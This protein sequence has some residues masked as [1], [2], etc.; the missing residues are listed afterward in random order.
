MYYQFGLSGFIQKSTLGHH[1]K[2]LTVSREAYYKLISIYP[3]TIKF[4]A[5]I[6][7]ER[8]PR[9]TFPLSLDKTVVLTKRGA[10]TVVCIEQRVTDESWRN[11]GIEFTPKEWSGLACAKLRGAIYKEF[12]RQDVETRLAVSDA[13]MLTA[14]RFIAITPTGHNVEGKW[15]LSRKHVGKEATTMGEKVYIQGRRVPKPSSNE[16]MSS[17]IA[18]HV[19][20]TAPDVVICDVCKRNSGPMPP[21]AST[22]CFGRLDEEVLVHVFDDI[23]DERVSGV[24]TRCFGR[25]D[26]EVL[27]RVLRDITDE[28]VAN[29]Y[30]RVLEE[31]GLPEITH[32]VRHL[33]IIIIISAVLL[34]LLYAIIYTCHYII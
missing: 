26:E 29:L 25:V 27:A 32:K 28:R 17:V 1:A 14:Y 3:L 33:I 7:S 16:M 30:R 13:E 12:A 22:R 15:C 10:L 24:S 18:H 9:V 23:G 19:L 20:L 8:K 21:G 5:K 6:K 4:L 11:W 31:L 2:R 34:L